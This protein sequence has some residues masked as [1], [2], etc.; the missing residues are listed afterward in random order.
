MPRIHHPPSHGTRLSLLLGLLGSLVVVAGFVF[1]GHFHE[2]VKKSTKFNWKKPVP[3]DATLRAELTPRQYSVVRENG[4]ETPFSN[5]Y[6]NNDRP[7]LYV[8]IISGEPLFSSAD[9]YDSG[10]GTPSF[11]KPISP[12]HIKE[13]Q[14]NS[15]GMNRTEVRSAWSDAHLGHLFHDG[16]P[17]TGFRYSIN[18]AA[19]RFI[20]YDQ[21]Q[22]QGYSDYLSLFPAPPTP[23]QAPSAVKQAQT[24]AAPL[25]G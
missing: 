13:R 22:I 17:P 11:T 7:G 2:V 24:P 14:D 3:S 21:L 25:H 10:L 4:N 18:S 12:E 16:P 19:L 23:T 6:W 5:E 15:F 8:D 20:P 9:K 1:Y